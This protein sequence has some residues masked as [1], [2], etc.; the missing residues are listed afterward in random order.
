MVKKGVK[1]L[2]VLPTHSPLQCQSFMRG[3][4]NENARKGVGKHGVKISELLALFQPRYKVL[5]PSL[6]DPDPWLVVPPFPTSV[7][8]DV[9]MGLDDDMS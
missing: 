2:V 4:G 5:P 9:W 6:K 7:G 8:Q 3:Q 1:I